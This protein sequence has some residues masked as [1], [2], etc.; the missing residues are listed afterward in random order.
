MRT[1]RAGEW[2]DNGPGVRNP[3]FR[4]RKF[5][6][7]SEKYTTLRLWF[8]HHCPILHIINRPYPQTRHFEIERASCFTNIEREPALVGISKD[9]PSLKII[10][11]ELSTV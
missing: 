10:V 6:E 8:V 11:P 1:D 7:F 3:H 9:I 5:E 2:F 4:I